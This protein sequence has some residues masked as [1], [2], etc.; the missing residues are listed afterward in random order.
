MRTRFRSAASLPMLCVVMQGRETTPREQLRG[1]QEAVAVAD[2]GTDVVEDIPPGGGDVEAPALA[3][4]G[5]DV[6]LAALH[7]L[8]HAGSAADAL[9][10]HP[11]FWRWVAFDPPMGDA[12]AV[13][14]SPRRVLCRV[15]DRELGVTDDP[16]EAL[17]IARR[18]RREVRRQR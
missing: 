18:H 14:Y 4:P 11:S 17:F 5:L 7:A 1:G 2:T 10:P 12:D 8:D 9:A 16:V 6:W 13:A 15:C 3:G